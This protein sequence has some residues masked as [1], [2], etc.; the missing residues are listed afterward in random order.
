MSLNLSGSFVHAAQY[1]SL[2]LQVAG[3]LFPDQKFF[4]LSQDQ[5]RI[6]DNETRAL[7][8]QA[9]WVVD[10]K[11]FADHFAIPQVGVETAPSGT[12][13]GDKPPTPDISGHYA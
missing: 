5:R 1:A 3:Q 11:A 8:V 6:V 10:S 2:T 12:V 7:L 9:R 4:G 13:L